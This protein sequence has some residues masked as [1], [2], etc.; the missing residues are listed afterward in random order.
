MSGSSKNITILFIFRPD[1]YPSTHFM[2]Q[3][4]SNTQP[5]KW[6]LVLSFFSDFF[7]LNVFEDESE[8]STAYLNKFFEYQ[9]NGST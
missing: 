7:E 8:Y 9:N 5:C 6:T 4:Q 1:K 2:I 3:T